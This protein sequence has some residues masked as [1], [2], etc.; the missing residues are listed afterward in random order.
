MQKQI[1]RAWCFLFL[2]KDQKNLLNFQDIYLG[3]ILEIKK[4]VKNYHQNRFIDI[5]NLFYFSQIAEN[6]TNFISLL[7]NTSPTEALSYIDNI[8]NQLHPIK[9]TDD[10][11]NLKIK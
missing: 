2:F 11:N 1:I 10:E 9:F 8:T 3:I 6:I 5:T 7:K 4:F